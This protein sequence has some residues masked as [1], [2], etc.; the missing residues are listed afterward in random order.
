MRRRAGA[1]N[2]P[3]GPGDGRN[4]R[5]DQYE[6]PAPTKQNLQAQTAELSQLED[7]AIAVDASYYIQLFLDNPP[8]HEPLLPALGGLTGIESHIESDLDSWQANKTT[9]FFIFNGQSVVGQDDVSIQRGKRAIVKTDEAWDLYFRSEATA[10]VTA[11]GSNRGAYPVQ[12]LFPLL[13]RILKKRNLHYLV[14]PYNASAQLA[15]FDMVDSEQCSAIMGGQE[16]LLYPIRD[17]VIRFIDWDT[18]VF[19]AISKKGL[20][21]TLN[22]SEPMFID[23][24]LMT[25]N[26]FLPSFPPLQ[27]T[28]I[29]PR[30]PFTVMDAVNMLRTS[31][32]AVATACNSFSDILQQKDPNWLQKYRK[33]RMTIDHFIYISETGEIKVHN[34]DT[35]THDNYEY[36][37]Y[38]LPAELFHYLNSGL[39]GPRTPAW[40]THG[41]IVVGPTLDGV[42]SD[43]Y[44]KLVTT[45][46]MPLREQALALL[47]PRLHRAIQFK[48]V[49]VKVW[50]DDKYLHTIEYRAGGNRAPEQAHTW[51]VKEST[52]NQYFPDAKHG[53]VVFEVT[54]LKNVDF[55]KA[56]ISKEKI[57]G[58]DSADLISSVTI[59]RF[60][61]LRG[62]VDDSHRL[63]V[64]GEALATSLEEI[65]PVARAN[66]D[67][68][69]A[70]S[71][72]LA[73]ELLRF[74][75]LHTRNQHPELS[76]LPM[77]G[78]DEDKASLLLISRCAIL[79]K[80]HHEA[81]G[82]TGP[83]SK[84]FL[85]FR[86][87]SSSIREANRDLIEALVASML[88]HAQG[89]KEREDY[90]D[91]GQRL[92]FLADTD[93]AL[94]IAVKTL[95]DDIHPTDTPEQKQTKR[96][97]FPGK[98][99]PYATSFFKD[100]NVAFDF[101]GALHAGV[102]QLGDEQVPA[103]DRKV[104]DRAAEYLKARQ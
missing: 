10:A 53:S 29:N 34:F 16:L 95:L 88:L 33:A 67:S 30:Q 14:P 1:D 101:F 82:Y 79:L 23:A 68:S 48:P 15:Y 50:Y 46:L 62:Y 2:I 4:T 49:H 44:K 65:E 76:G 18:G 28:T 40:I 25:G 87:L 81:N 55:A 69:P 71:V 13:Q 12:H 83:L 3:L 60:L 26:S 21:R 22:V 6:E 41:Q 93:V 104:W 86:S 54:A 74:D 52:I 77:N 39:I 98:Y 100:L 37:G 27:D 102:K 24:L 38:Q 7:T 99:V 47:L 91:I 85:C 36:L 8:Y 17:H 45:Q 78:S 11:F 70:E 103:A 96:A 84:N 80:L 66:P 61:H 19:R 31:E 72:L 90:S 43:E 89:K 5:R 42:N 75:L 57:K 56:T 94:G 97:E 35:L 64:W 63:T 73:Y 32:K 51:D 58:V 9:P 59:W 20:I 92:P